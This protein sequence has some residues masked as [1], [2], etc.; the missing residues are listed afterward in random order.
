M[1]LYRTGTLEFKN[2]LCIISRVE[3]KGIHG[4]SE[5][6]GLSHISQIEAPYNKYIY[7]RIN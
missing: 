4:G 5:S 1:I 6:Y 2:D 3:V 7:E